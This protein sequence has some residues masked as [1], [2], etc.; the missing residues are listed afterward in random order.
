[1]RAIARIERRGVRIPAAL[2]AHETHKVVQVCL[3]ERVFVGCHA[4]AAVADA[5]FDVVVVDRQARQ[6]RSA[7]V[8]AGELRGVVGELVVA[9]PAL[10]IEDFS[11][12]FRPA[13]GGLAKLVCLEGTL[14]VILCNGRLRSALRR[15]LLGDRRR[16]ERASR[17]YQ[18]GPHSLRH[19]GSH[20]LPL[21]AHGRVWCMA[22]PVAST[23]MA[24]PWC[25]PAWAFGGDAVAP[26]EI[27]RP[28]HIRFAMLVV[29]ASP[30][31]RTGA[32]GAWPDH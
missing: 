17:D 5:V 7:L 32:F 2:L 3:A 6:Q 16:R 22:G 10:V 19:V 14:V 1:M 29:I 30:F 11:T 18:T 26:A 28:A 4:G 13:L 8:E 21:C 31:A 12:A 24:P 9:E 20:C 15:R 27:I 25:A 23:K